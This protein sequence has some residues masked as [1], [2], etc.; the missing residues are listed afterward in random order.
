MST[1]DLTNLAQMEEAFAFMLEAI[2]KEPAGPVNGAAVWWK[3]Y[4]KR[5]G[6]LPDPPERWIAVASERLQGDLRR[7]EGVKEHEATAAARAVP[8]GVLGH[9]L[10]WAAYFQAQRSGSRIP[11]AIRSGRAALEG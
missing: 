5:K 8:A 7:V 6:L 11:D 3:D 10:F 9:P 1:T 2:E 4:L